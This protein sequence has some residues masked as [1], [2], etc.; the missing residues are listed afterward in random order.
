MK[1]LMS[2]IL[3]ILKAFWDSPSLPMF[4]L[5]LGAILANGMEIIILD[6]YEHITAVICLIVFAILYKL[7]I[8]ENKIEGLK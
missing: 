6:P 5:S 7:D 4:L 1:K 2:V 3:T 8:I